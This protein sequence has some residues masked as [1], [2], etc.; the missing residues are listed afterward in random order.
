LIRIDNESRRPIMTIR[1]RELANDYT[2][3][4]YAC[5]MAPVGTFEE[6]KLLIRILSDMMDGMEGPAKEQGYKV[7][8]SDH[9]F[10][11]EAMMFDMLRAENP[12][13]EIESAIGLGATLRDADCGTM[14]SLIEDLRRAAEMRQVLQHE[15]ENPEELV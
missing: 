3:F 13:S 11:I 1:N 10:E 4:R 14:D 2:N 8:N 9:A 5:D 15:A 6:S 7:C 12:D